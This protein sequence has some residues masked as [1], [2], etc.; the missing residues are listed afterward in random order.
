MR[1]ATQSILQH[2]RALVSERSRLCVAVA[3]VLPI[4]CALAVVAFLGAAA[5]AQDR[6]PVAVVNLDEGATD[7]DGV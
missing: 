7:A 1:V 3:A 6:I 2:I 5:D 4:V